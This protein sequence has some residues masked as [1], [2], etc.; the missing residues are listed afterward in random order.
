MIIIFVHMVIT[1]IH[2]IIPLIISIIIIDRQKAGRK[3][4]IKEGLSLLST[5]VVSLIWFISIIDVTLITGEKEG[6]KVAIIIGT[7][8]VINGRRKEGSLPSFPNS[9]LASFLPSPFLSC[10][11]CFSPLFLPSHY[12]GYYWRE[13]R[14]K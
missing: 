3:E 11:L 4:G 8:I 10:F 14:K 9:F 5:S 6:R 1:I 2:T 12:A 7:I 13:G